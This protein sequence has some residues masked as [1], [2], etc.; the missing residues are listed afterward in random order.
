LTLVEASEASNDAGRVIGSGTCLLDEL[1]A[2]SMSLFG[3]SGDIGSGL[4]YDVEGL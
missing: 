2:G 1:V 3:D 4:V